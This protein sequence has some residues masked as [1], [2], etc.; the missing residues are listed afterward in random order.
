ME[1]PGVCLAW[2]DGGQTEGWFTWSLAQL[3][4]LDSRC[5][6]YVTG[7]RGDM[8]HLQSS[9]RIHEAR[10]QVVDMFARL[11]QQPEWLFMLD[12]DM[13]F[14][15]DVLERMMQIADPRQ[16][17]I[18]GGLAFGGGRANDPFPTIYKLT[19]KRVGEYN[20]PSV[21]KVYDYP[22][23]TLVKVG[24]TGAACL[25]VHRSVLGAMKNAF[26]YLADGRRNPYPWFPEGVHGAE[27]EGWGE[28]TAFCLRAFAIGAPVHVHTGIRFGHIKSHIIDEVYY[29]NR[30]AAQAQASV[31]GHQTR[32]ER[33]RMAR[34][35]S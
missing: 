29:D 23:D 1:S 34:Q 22:R 30:R 15:P 4:T 9:P 10:N 13:T 26:E 19:E 32:A 18:L 12:A 28:D 20:Y 2:I 7:E 17:P 16:V 14:E 33:R 31:N 3:I 35:R 8:I 6:Q 27:G 11:E 21:E 5:S 25:L 24:A